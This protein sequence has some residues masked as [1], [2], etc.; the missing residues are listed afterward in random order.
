MNVITSDMTDSF[1][2]L[3]AWR[4]AKRLNQRKA[5]KILRI[6]QSTY[7]LLE[8]QLRFVKGKR[9]KAIMEKTRVPL[10]VLVGAK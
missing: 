4:E 5:A 9:A 3:K 2:S 7:G 10:E 1:A 8:R 6:S